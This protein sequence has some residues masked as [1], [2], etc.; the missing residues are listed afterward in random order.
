MELVY[1]APT[2]VVARRGGFC[3][4]LEGVDGYY[5]YLLIH[6]GLLCMQAGGTLPCTFFFSFFVVFFRGIPHCVDLSGAKAE[7]GQN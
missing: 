5:V 1:G 7:T 3:F 4:S 6:V 2:L